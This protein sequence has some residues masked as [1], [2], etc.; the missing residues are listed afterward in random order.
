MLPPN[1]VSLRDVA[2]AAG[3]SRMTASRALRNHPECAPATRA[4]VQAEAARLGWRPDAALLEWMR[5]VR[6]R[7][8]GPGVRAELGW[9]WLQDARGE[10]TRYV[11]ADLHFAGARRR[12]T[13]AG[14]ALVPLEARIDGADAPRVLRVLRARGIRGVILY[15]PPGGEH[16]VGLPVDAFASVVFGWSIVHPRLHRVVENY[17]DGLRRALVHAV[18]LGYRR[19]ALAL[20]RQALLNTDDGWLR[21]FLL[22]QVRNGFAPGRDQPP[23]LFDNEPDLGVRLQHWLRSHAPD[24]IL[25]LDSFILDLLQERGVR[26]PEDVGY[27]SLSLKPGQ[28][29]MAGVDLQLEFTG[30]LA[31]DVV[32]TQLHLGEAGVPAVPR[33]GHVETRW[34]DGPTLRPQRAAR[35]T[36]GSRKRPRAA[37]RAV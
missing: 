9:L 21:E 32:V 23:F 13:E 16:R 25:G 19:P 34:C 2:A 11:A 33:E 27:A 12:A 6:R 26:V 20:H 14:Y 15:A 35:P 29:P 7:R 4:R 10:R 8:A 30:E 3:V 37:T 36:S 5:Q 31:V 18:A 28:R 1:P 22:W 17:R 24:V